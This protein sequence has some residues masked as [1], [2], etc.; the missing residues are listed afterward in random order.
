[1]KALEVLENVGLG[2]E[3][4]IEISFGNVKVKLWGLR[5]E[6]I[7]SKTGYVMK[8]WFQLFLSRYGFQSI[9]VSDAD[10]PG[11]MKGVSVREMLD[12]YLHID[13]MESLS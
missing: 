9:S 10:F 1:M 11:G 3:A 4:E 5:I 8:V 7:E 12:I 13:D 2:G 6:D